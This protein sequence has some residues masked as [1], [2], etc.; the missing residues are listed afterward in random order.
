MRF[1]EG[2]DL[3]HRQRDSL[4]GFFPREYAHF[5][6]WREHRAL[7]SDGVWVRGD[8]VR[9]DQNRVLTS[10]DEIAC[11]GEDEVG[12]GF[13]HPGHKLVGRLD[14][15]LGPLSHQRR[16]PALPEC[17][18]VFRIAHL[19][20]PA[21]GLRQYSRGNPIGCALQEAPDERAANAET[22]HHELVDAQMIHQAEL[23][24]GIGIPRPFDLDRASGLA[25]GSVAQVR[26]DAA[27]LSLELLNGV[28][29]RVTGEE[30]YGRVQSAAGKQHQGEAGSGL[31]IVDASG[32]F[33][34]ELAS[35]TRLLSKYARYGGRCGC[36]GACC[37][38]GASGRT[39]NRYP[40]ESLLQPVCAAP[41]ASIC[42]GF[43]CATL[44]F[45]LEY[46]RG[47]VLDEGIKTIE[48]PSTASDRRCSG[49]G[50]AGRTR[51]SLGRGQRAGSTGRSARPL[52]RTV[53]V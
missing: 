27:I 37:Q 32:A 29:G 24:V 42:P 44:R 34:V 15:D 25:G 46:N 16:T 12:V 8:L 17:A 19:R 7:H 43:G 41:H 28:E 35:F 48:P 30:G 9:Q 50:A 4:L 40:P 1:E 21:H 49:R 2:M 14:L 52:R 23:V 3:A 47:E 31:F 10:P 53:A 13:E 5:R 6:L 18:W 45:R 38:Y 39:H 36:R 51:G 26:R 20:T 22:H 11:H 33:F